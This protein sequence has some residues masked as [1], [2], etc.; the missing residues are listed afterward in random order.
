MTCV[1]L[2]NPFFHAVLS[3]D[4][5][6]S[7]CVVGVYKPATKE[8]FSDI[9]KTERAQSAMIVPIVQ[10]VLNKAGVEFKDIGLIITTIGPGSFTG[11]RIGMTTAM[12]M[13]MSLGVP[14]QG[15]GTIDVMI[16]TC[17][18]DKKSRHG[19]AC[20]LETKRGDFYFGAMD[21]AF[22]KNGDYFSGTHDQITSQCNGKKMTLCGDAVQRFLSLGAAD[23]F[24][25]VVECDMLDAQILCEH[26]LNAFFDAGQESKRP[27]PLYLRGA[28]VSKSSKL[29]REIGDYPV[30]L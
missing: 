12:T 26:G 23:I 13:G 9:F 24:E 30:L 25:G 29:Q 15:V 14:V 28:D 4:T 8:I 17:A 27:E 18:K 16:K 10:G 5:S 2:F 3:I 22:E 11:L 19:Y 6:L 7:G 21:G 20:V 1:K